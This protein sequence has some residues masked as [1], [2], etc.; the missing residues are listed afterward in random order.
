MVCLGMFLSVWCVSVCF[1]LYGVS[2]YVSTCMVCLGM[3]LSGFYIWEYLSLCVCG[4]QDEYVN[5]REC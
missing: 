4:V 1:Y 3:F 2:W 5:S